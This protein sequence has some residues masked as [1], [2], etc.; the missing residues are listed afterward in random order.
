M[1]IHWVLLQLFLLLLFLS[2]TTYVFKFFIF[3]YA[4][5]IIFAIPFPSNTPFILN[6]QWQSVTNTIWWQDFPYKKSP[7]C[8][9]LFNQ[10]NGSMDND[11]RSDFAAQLAGFMATLVTDVPSEAYWIV[12]LTKYDFGGASG[13]LVASVPGIHSYRSLS[14]TSPVSSS[15]VSKLQ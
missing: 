13:Y 11:L 9:S 7:D 1:I 15:Q 12:E 10:L 3:L 8:K 5:K 14:A 6:L 2:L 4:P